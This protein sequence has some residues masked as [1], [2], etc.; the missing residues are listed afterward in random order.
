MA[1]GPRSWTGTLFAQPRKQAATLHLT[2][3][4]SHNRWQYK[5]YL[6]FTGRGPQGPEM[7]ENQAAP[8]SGTGPFLDLVPC[9]HV[10]PCAGQRQGPETAVSRH[11]SLSAGGGLTTCCQLST[12]ENLGFAMSTAKRRPCHSCP[13][14][15]HVPN[16]LQLV[17][18]L[19]ALTPGWVWLLPAPLPARP[20]G[21][22]GGPQ[23]PGI[24]RSHQGHGR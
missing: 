5:A 4:Q 23:A 13:G 1:P 18:G 8:D 21:R 22:P 24:Q 9:P 7:H 11:K 19:G 3:L 2:G 10:A 17:P 6:I 14:C 12:S 16:T 20:A 15:S